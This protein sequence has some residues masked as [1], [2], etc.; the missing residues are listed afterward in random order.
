MFKI[1]GLMQLE[2]YS[3]LAVRI[4]MNDVII[5]GKVV[6]LDVWQIIKLSNET[7]WFIEEKKGNT[8]LRTQ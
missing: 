3:S 1:D 8:L 6:L 4:G 5:S 7:A 2:A